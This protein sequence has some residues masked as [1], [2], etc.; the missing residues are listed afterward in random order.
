M[1]D[2]FD[3]IDFLAPDPSKAALDITGLY[4]FEAPHDRTRSVLILAVNPFALGAAFD[5]AA[6]YRIDVDTDGDLESDLAFNVVFSAAEHGRQSATVFRAT[7]ADARSRGAAGEV[8][9]EDAATSSWDSVLVAES[10]PYRFFAGPRSDPFF[11]D[12]EGLFNGYRFT[13]TDSF[14]D[15]DVFAIALEVPN[16]DLGSGPAAIWGRTI[17][18]SN[19][20]SAQVDRT[21]GS[22]LMNFLTYGTPDEIKP[23]REA[24]PSADVSRFGKRYARI[25]EGLG[26]TADEARIIVARLL[27]DV[28]HFDH[29]RPATFPNGRH[30]WDD[31][32]DFAVALMTQGRVTSDG[33][34]PHED[35]ESAF[36]HLG[37]PHGPAGTAQAGA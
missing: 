36:P 21:G 29:R 2:H 16:E 26:Y 3:F 31:L 18:R 25:L 37:A 10:A 34:G 13:G 12:A 22:N 32:T 17:S 30:L 14:G 6:I 1:S 8:I 20:R 5:P 19:G 27:P 33:V 11:A 7:G 15:K 24:E 23:Y 9:V 4:A 28:L 35:Y